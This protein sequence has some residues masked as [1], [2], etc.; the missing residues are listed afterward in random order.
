[1]KSYENEV[2]GG[3]GDVADGA[4][5]L[6][7]VEIPILT[8]VDQMRKHGDF[9]VSVINVGNSGGVGGDFDEMAV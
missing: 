9:L 2:S 7:V 3:D 5:F 6:C 8:N 4:G 1:L